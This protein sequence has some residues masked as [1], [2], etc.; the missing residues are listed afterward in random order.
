MLTGWQRVWSGWKWYIL[1]YVRVKPKLYTLTPWVKFLLKTSSRSA[2]Q[3]IPLL[4]WNTKVYFRVQRSPSLRS[5]LNCQPY[6]ICILTYGYCTSCLN[7]MLIQVFGARLYWRLQFVC[8]R[9]RV[10]FKA[11]CSCRLL[12]C[13]H[14]HTP[15]R[16]FCHVTKN[17]EELGCHMLN[18]SSAVNTAVS[19]FRQF[20]KMLSVNQ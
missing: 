14:Y 1:L 9:A 19:R 13:L 5:V 4:L 20:A 16:F 3:D 18:V 8:L 11:F 17:S 2:T 7:N 12:H 15:Y 6:Y 10:L